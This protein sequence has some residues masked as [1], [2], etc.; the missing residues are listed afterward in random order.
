MAGFCTNLDLLVKLTSGGDLKNYMFLY[1]SIISVLNTTVSEEDKNLIKE[2][3]RLFCVSLNK[4]WTESS[5]SQKTFMN[6]INNRNWLEKNINWPVF[7]S[8]DLRSELGFSDVDLS[9]PVDVNSHVPNL[10]VCTTE[11]VTSTLYRKPFEDLCNKQKKRR[12]TSIV[13]E[14]SEEEL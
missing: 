11:A 3:C 13:E 2:F 7:D 5:R 9:E 4:K 10:A 6:R 12:S 1:E 8:V 14:N